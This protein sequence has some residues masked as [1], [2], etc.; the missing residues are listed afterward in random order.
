MAVL[1]A[2]L[3][4]VKVIQDNGDPN[5]LIFFER[6]KHANLL[7]LDMFC[8][9]LGTE[10]SQDDDAPLPCEGSEDFSILC[11]WK[12]CRILRFVPT[13]DFLRSCSCSV[14]QDDSEDEDRPDRPLK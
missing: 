9:A 14:G 5:I 8:L 11:H 13:T 2:R 3:R 12:T 6:K 4:Y 10:L 1:C 7:T